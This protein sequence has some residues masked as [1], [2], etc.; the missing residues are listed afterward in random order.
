[1][2]AAKPRRGR[3]LGDIVLF[4]VLGAGLI[5]AGAWVG[6]WSFQPPAPKPATTTAEGEA[7][8]R[9]GTVVLRVDP[10]KC[11]RM[12]FDNTTGSFRDGLLASCEEMLAVPRHGL[13]PENVDIVRRGFYPR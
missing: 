4:V 5:A 7:A 3:A 13:R 6:R 1:M 10:I 8:I 12:S 11:L 2:A 9:T